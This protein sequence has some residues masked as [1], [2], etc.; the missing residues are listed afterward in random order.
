LLNPRPARRGSVPL[1]LHRFVPV[2][3]NERPR[4]MLAA[5]A[6]DRR[7]H[8]PGWH[9]GALKRTGLA[10][11]RWL[12]FERLNPASGRCDPSY[13]DIAAGANIHT[14]TVRHALARL[15]EAGFLIVTPRRAT[16]QVRGRPFEVQWRNAYAFG[17]G[18][19]EASDTGYPGRTTREEDQ[20]LI[21]PA[22]VKLDRTRGLL[23]QH[24][25]SGQRVV[26]DGPSRLYKRTKT[27]PS[28]APPPIP[29][30]GCDLLAARRAAMEAR[31]R[32]G[33]PSPSG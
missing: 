12:L 2:D 15:A 21:E 26:Q 30:P 27:A 18:R 22:W 4:I 13:A 5:H 14:D 29:H 3:R 9:G 31:W 6:Y 23:L 8:R 28:V 10:V 33:C 20:E 11:L 25:R 1:R 7:T 16:V 17:R 32:A 19:P 24:R